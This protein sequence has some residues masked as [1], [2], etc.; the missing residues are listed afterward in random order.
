MLGDNE[1]A[2]EDLDKAVSLDPDSAELRY[3]RGAVYADFG[4][5]RKDTRYLSMAV[6]DLKEARELNQTEPDE[7]RKLAI[8]AN[9]RRTLEVIANTGAGIFARFNKDRRKI[10]GRARKALEILY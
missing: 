6:E 10:A 7:Y 5:A 1:H 8:D 2:F 4:E 3:D 9:T